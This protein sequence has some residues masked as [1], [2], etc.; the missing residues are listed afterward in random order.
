MPI[1]FPKRIPRN[2]IAREF[3]ACPYCARELDAPENTA[4]CGEIGHE[5]YVVTLKNGKTLYSTQDN[6]EVVEHEDFEPE[7]HR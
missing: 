7:D 1:E 2:Q 3:F 6:F 4:C 5:E